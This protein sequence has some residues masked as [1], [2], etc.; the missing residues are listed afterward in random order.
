[1]GDVSRAAGLNPYVFAM[2][3]A[4]VEGVVIK[5]RRLGW[6]DH[7]AR[8]E[9]RAAMQASPEPFEAVA[10]QLLVRANARR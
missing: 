8:T 2:R 5:L 1:M 4:A 7:H 9:L 3:C 6:A 10:E